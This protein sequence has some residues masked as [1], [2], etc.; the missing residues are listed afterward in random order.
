MQKKVYTCKKSDSMKKVLVEIMLGCNV[1]RVVCVDSTQRVIGI[2]SQSD[3]AAVCSFS[4]GECILFR[5]SARELHP[6]LT[7]AQKPRRTHQCTFSRRG[8]QTLY[9]QY[10]TEDALRLKTDAAGARRS[11]KRGHGKMERGYRKAR[12]EEPE[13]R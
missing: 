6:N 2:I 4:L 10:T 9:K 7:R 3:M 1:R 12:A 8:E 13:N 11:E 5:N